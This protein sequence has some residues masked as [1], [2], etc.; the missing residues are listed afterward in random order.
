MRKHNLLFGVLL[1]MLFL[2]SGCYGSDRTKEITAVGTLS[3]PDTKPVDT[4]PPRISGV[5]NIVVYAGDPVDY[6]KDII[7]T[8]D[9]DLSPELSVDS[10]TVDLTVPGTYTVRYTAYDLAGNTIT[11]KAAVTV[12]EKEPGYRSIEEIYR[13]ADEQLAQ[14]VTEDMTVLEQVQAIYTWARRNIS[15]GGHSDRQDW[16]QTAYTT[17]KELRGDCYGYFAVT[18]LMFE[19]LNIPNIDVQ[20][21]KNFEGDSDHF[22]SMVSV[23]SGRS[24]YHFDA[25]PRVGSGD[26]FCLVTD[27]FLD[28]YSQTHKNS[29]NREASLY[30][31]TPEV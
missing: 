1:T 18:K 16:R 24:W 10:E 28:A 6:R 9:T 13:A 26:D 3:R 17:L 22:W 5:Q 21:V 23:D 14:I 2:L 30:P 31:P 19:R 27:A 8:D 25:T 20:K 29:H 4:T 15:Y 12:L 11:K 7:V